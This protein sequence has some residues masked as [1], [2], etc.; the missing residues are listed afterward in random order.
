[1]CHFSTIFLNDL[2]KELIAMT[3]VFGGI[4]LEYIVIVYNCG[5]KRI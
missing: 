5:N 4:L 3:V 1:M 2:R